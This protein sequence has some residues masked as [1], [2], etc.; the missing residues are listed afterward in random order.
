MS[1][2][3]AT[4]NVADYLDNDEVIAEYLT[5]AAEDENTDVLLAAL[6]EVAKA[7]GMSQ[8]AA[9]AGLGRES[10]Y[11]ALAP[12]SHPRFETIAAV[13]RALKVRLSVTPIV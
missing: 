11:K 4:F 7:R 1:T 6:A 9:A 10:L 3:F 5:A 2:D 13:L 12:G 8:V